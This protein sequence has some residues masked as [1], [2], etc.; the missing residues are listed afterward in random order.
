MNR[1]ISLAVCLFACLLVVQGSRAQALT[2]D[3]YR[4]LETFANILAVAQKNSVPAVSTKEMLDGAIKGMLSSL[5]PH[6]AYLTGERYRDLEVHTR[7]VFGGIG[8]TVMIKNGVLT[9]NAPMKDTPAER[10]GIKA[11]DQI[12]KIN[13]DPTENMSLDGAVSRMRGPRG[14]SI[15]LTLRRDGVREPF[16]LSVAREVIKIQSVDSNRID[17]YAYIRLSGFQEA[18]DQEIEKRL[19]GF[20]K[21]DHGRIA[22]LVFDLRG[23]PGGLLSQAVKVSEQFLNGGLVVYTQ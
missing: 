16:T 1:R 4:Q 13:N 17:G 12:I 11:G 15:R 21:E 23:N 7:G 14:S 2:E 6:S 19:D 10:A 8:I 22:G 5:D 20:R 9:V 3:D 18:S